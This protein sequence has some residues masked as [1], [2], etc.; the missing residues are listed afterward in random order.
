M[1]FW[2]CTP[3]TMDLSFKA[4]SHKLEFEHKTSSPGYPQSKGK[5]EQ[6]VKAA[7]TLMKKA[8]KAGTGPCLS[9]LSQRNTHTQGLDSSP[10]QHLVRRTTK[11]LLPT[12]ANL[13]IPKLWV[14]VD[15]KLFLCKHRQAHHYN[16]GAK[17]LEEIRNQLRPLYNPRLA[18]EHTSF[19]LRMD[20]C[21]SVTAVTRESLKSLCTEA[22]L[23]CLWKAWPHLPGM[24]RIS[25][26]TW[27][28]NMSQNAQPF[29]Q[30]QYQSK[31]RYKSTWTRQ[32][33]RATVIS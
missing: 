20:R 18:Y 8:K 16:K 27:R 19:A 2:M 7:K 24:M 30:Q 23:W 26:W 4:F 29:S 9:L 31:I 11:T 5:A 25:H 14:N 32:E 28:R 3:Q 1:V 12:T 10:V 22:F 17:D 21:M 13:L 15:K 33:G 6:A